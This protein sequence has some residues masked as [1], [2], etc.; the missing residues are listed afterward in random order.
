MVG[1]WLTVDFP[2]TAPDHIVGFVH[3]HF[4]QAVLF[5]LPLAQDL[6]HFLPALDLR[7]V[8]GD[9]PRGGFEVEDALEPVLA[10]RGPGSSGE[11]LVGVFCLERG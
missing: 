2:N 3:G 5:P 10:P 9:D 7:G 4:F 11:R 6:V 8:Q 1:V